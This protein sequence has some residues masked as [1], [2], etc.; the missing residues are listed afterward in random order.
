MLKKS[1]LVALAVGLSL[2]VGYV[3]N[4]TR[5]IADHDHAGG[6]VVSRSGGTDKYGCHTDHKN[7]GYHCHN[8]K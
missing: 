2:G 3:A 1:P 6:T 8:P 5:L 4:G 7:G